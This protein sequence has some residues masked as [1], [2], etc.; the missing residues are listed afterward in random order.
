MASEC[1]SRAVRRTAA[2]ETFGSSGNSGWVAISDAKNEDESEITQ[3]RAELDWKLPSPAHDFVGR[4]D[5]FLWGRAV[6]CPTVI[7]PRLN[8]RTFL[9][10]GEQEDLLIGRLMT[11]LVTRVFFFF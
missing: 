9:D 11:D 8:P 2:A 10:C 6:C 7:A 1:S 5:L 4:K 3:A